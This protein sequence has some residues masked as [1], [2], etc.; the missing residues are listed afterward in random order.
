VTE[1]IRRGTPLEVWAWALIAVITGSV[2]ATFF[3]F[4]YLWLLS[5][6]LLPL[7]YFS[8]SRAILLSAPAREG[9]HRGRLV[10]AL[11]F[12]T[13]IVTAFLWRVASNLFGAPGFTD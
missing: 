7:A 2:A 4:M 8:W 10:M 5:L 12:G 3:C 11:I 9:G 1:N 13:I 6:L